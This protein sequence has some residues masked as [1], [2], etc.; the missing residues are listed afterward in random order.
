VLPLAG[1]GGGSLDA[2]TAPLDEG[3]VVSPQQYLADSAAAAAA[4]GRFLETADALGAQP[5]SAELVAAAPV[6]DEQLAEFRVLR[7]RLDAARLDDA[8]LESQRQAVAA[9]TAEL[10]GSMERFVVFAAEGDR[11]GVA[12]ASRELAAD[13][14]DVR[15]AAAT[16]S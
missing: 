7:A 5:S 11:R 16:D 13:V 4:A 8:R 14:D 6:L 9:A 3:E 2:G 15:T 12:L 1:C 10:E